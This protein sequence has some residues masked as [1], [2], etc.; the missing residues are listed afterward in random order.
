M[1]KIPGAW[2]KLAC[3]AAIEENRLGVVVGADDRQVAHQREEALKIEA[4]D[5][6]EVER[7]GVQFTTEGLLE[8]VTLVHVVDVGQP[9]REAS[10]M[11][12]REAHPRVF[13]RNREDLDGGPGG[14]PSDTIVDRGVPERGVHP[15]EAE[16]DHIELLRQLAQGVIGTDGGA[17]VRRERQAV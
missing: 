1:A 16:H 12:P 3:H 2:P 4:V 13:L 7:T 6:H 9:G 14:E 8:V 17:V 11:V 15:V 10:R 5:V